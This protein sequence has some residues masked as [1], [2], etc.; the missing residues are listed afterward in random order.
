[1]ALFISYSSQDN[2]WADDLFKELKNLD[3]QVFYDKQ[4]L[5]YGST[6][7]ELTQQS[8]RKASAIVVIISHNYSSSRWSA[9]ELGAALAQNKKI[10]PVLI[11]D[12]KAIPPNISNLSYLDGRN[13]NVK[14]IAK[15]IKEELEKK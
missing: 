14:I 5:R 6:F 8:L 3:V 13:K 15:E 4:D 9:F 11:D 10:I 12:P 2:N 7:S 1:M